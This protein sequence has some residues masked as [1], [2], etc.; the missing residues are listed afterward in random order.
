MKNDATVSNL[1]QFFMTNQLL[2]HDLGKIEKKFGIDLGRDYVNISQADQDYYPQIEQSIRNEAAAMAPHYEVFYSLEKSVK[3]LITETLLAAEGTELWDSS[4][5]STQLRATAKERQ[6]KE[7]DS[8]VTPRSTEGI[9]F[10]TFG[11]LG[12]IIKQN[13]D[14]FGSIFTSVKAVEKV[15][16][17]LNTLRAPVA[18]CS[19][20]ADDEIVRLRLAVRDWFRLME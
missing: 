1:K 3:A 7:I 5:V 19:P 18:H 4:R 2:E 11:E 15:M 17:S 8:G 6:T 12:E 14:L 16:S 13:W 20:L 9:D 10:C